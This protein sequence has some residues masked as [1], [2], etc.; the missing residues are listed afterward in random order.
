[1]ITRKIGR[2][3]LQVSALCLGGNVFGWT[4][5]EPTSFSV[6]DTF[7]EGGGNFVDT[8]DVYSTWVAGHSGGESE[9]ILGKWLNQRK[10]REQMVIATK[11][12]A[13]MGNGE[14]GLTR[15]HIMKG[16]EDSLRRLQTD[17]IDLYQAHIDD[18]AVPLEE[19]LEAFNALIKAGKVRYIGASNYTAERLTA[20]LR[21]SLQQGYG[22]YECIQPPYHLLNRATYE[23]ELESLC[24]EQEI[25]VITYSSLA[26]GFLTG[27]YRANQDLP[28]SPRAQNIQKN[29]MNEKGFKVLDQLEFIAQAHDAT[30]AQVAL[31][32]TIGRPGIT[33]PIAS[34]TSVAQTQELLQSVSLRLTQDEGEA[35]DRVS[36]W[37]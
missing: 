6:L 15:Q 17:Y 24:L 31:A 28:S 11:V 12:G 5:D 14:Q 33:A 34:A 16:V 4:C 36:A 23:G 9:A 19:T 1:M 22:R 7:V 32:W 13:R 30:M 37:R 21:V 2:T 27:K 10:N 18:Q 26:S 8:A 20:A 35:L 3:E 25:G 29:Y